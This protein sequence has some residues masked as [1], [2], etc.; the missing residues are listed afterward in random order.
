MRKSVYGYAGA[1]ERCIFSAVPSSSAPG[2]ILNPASGIYSV[3]CKSTV[4]SP[5]PFGSLWNPEQ[6]SPLPKE[7]YPASVCGGGDTEEP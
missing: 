2:G 5:L 3:A 1:L 7:L 4:W 6:S